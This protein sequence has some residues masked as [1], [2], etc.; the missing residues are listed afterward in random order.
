[1]EE[2]N[3]E[4]PVPNEEEEVVEEVKVNKPIPLD[5]IGKNTPI[6]NKKKM[7][8]K[9]RKVTDFPHDPVKGRTFYKWAKFFFT[10]TCFGTVMAGF[11]LALP[12]FL[13][14]IGLFSTLIWFFYIVV[15]SIITIGL[16]WTISETSEFINGWSAF[17]NSLFNAAETTHGW[18]K[19]SIVWI[20]ISGAI[21][22]FTT[23]ILMIVGISKDK[24]RHKS[25]LG[26]IIALSIIT[27]VYIAFL[28]LNMSNMK[29]V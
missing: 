3:I 27:V 24:E 8:R 13:A 29:N 10:L 7:S 25:Y 6:P 2:Q 1:M 5:Q 4:K 17:N 11:M 16:I 28:V 20:L 22:I 26:R 18:Y 23:W 9:E 14:I 21:V 19:A 15:A 12:I